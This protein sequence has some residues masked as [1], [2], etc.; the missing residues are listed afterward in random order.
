[1]YDV[2]YQNLINRIMMSSSSKNW[3]F[4]VNEWRIYDCVE[5]AYAQSTCVCGRGNNRFLFALVNNTNGN[6][7]YPIG[8]ESIK[9]LGRPDL[10]EEAAMYE[11][12][13]ELLHAIMENKYLSLSPKIF[14]RKVLDYLYAN[15]AFTP[16]QYNE[17]NGRNDYNFILECIYGDAYISKSEQRKAVAIILQSIKPF[18]ESRFGSKTN[19]KVYPQYNNDGYYNYYNGYRTNSYRNYNGGYRKRNKRWY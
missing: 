4:A 18:I 9:L 3:A 11:E 2:Y 16:N 10:V 13:F 15:G 17:F 14:S 1:M 12:L 5:D 6:V 7:I 19:A 8:S